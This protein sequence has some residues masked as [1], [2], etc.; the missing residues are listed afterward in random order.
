MFVVETNFKDR[1]LYIYLYFNFNSAIDS[2][3]YF[4]AFSIYEKETLIQNVYSINLNY[5]L[6]I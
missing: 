3:A 2:I 5:D 6:I 4:V 1:K